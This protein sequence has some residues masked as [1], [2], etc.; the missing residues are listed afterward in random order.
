MS[1]RRCKLCGGEATVALVEHDGTTQRQ[2][3][4]CARC[5]PYGADDCRAQPSASGPHEQR[6][7]LGEW[8]VEARQAASWSEL[9]RF[10][11]EYHQPPGGAKAAT[12]QEMQRIAPR[13]ARMAGRLTGEMPATVRDFLR[14]YGSPAG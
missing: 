4:Y 8:E 9:E 2:R 10:L 7:P 5:A 12:E 3:D 1:Q 11:V 14:K 13:V 6:E